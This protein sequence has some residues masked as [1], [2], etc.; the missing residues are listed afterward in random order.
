[1]KMYPQLT[2]EYIRD[3]ISYV[4]LVMLQHVIP[5]YRTSD[6]KGKLGKPGKQGKS[7]KPIKHIDEILMGFG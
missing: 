7:G 6:N 4:N 5:P 3:G 2:R 1:M